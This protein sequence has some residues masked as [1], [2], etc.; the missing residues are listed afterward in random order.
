MVQDLTT[1][2]VRRC[3]HLDLDTEVSK[4]ESE[5]TNVRIGTE[6]LDDEVMV[7]ELGGLVQETG[8]TIS[9]VRKGEKR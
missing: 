7:E 1:K 5:T 2:K 8:D 6:F 4:W 3:R 9:D